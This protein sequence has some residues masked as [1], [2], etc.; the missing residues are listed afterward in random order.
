MFYRKK[1]ELEGVN[2]GNGSSHRLIT[3]KD[4][5]GF[6]VAHT[7]VNAGSES[8]LQYERH[9]EACYCISGSGKVYNKDRS[10][11]FNIEPGDIYALNEH[12][13]HILVANE[14]EDMH[15]VSVF[16]PPLNGDERHKL[17]PEGFS[18]Y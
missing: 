10:I 7:V 5:M 9:L 6:T 17:D 18:R 14:G 3:K 16:N 11:V 1:D 2:W 4:N 13:P 12:D 8:R 15:L